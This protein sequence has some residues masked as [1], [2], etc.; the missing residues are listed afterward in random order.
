ME[1]AIEQRL[2]SIEQKLDQVQKDTKRTYQIM[3]WTA[4]VGVAV[5]VLPL[6]GLI[7]VIPQFINTYANIGGL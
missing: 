6:I 1:P 7:F 5:F 2:S 4:I 3:L